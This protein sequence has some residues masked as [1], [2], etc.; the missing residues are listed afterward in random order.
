MPR[1]KKQPI[2]NNNSI[3][4][5]PQEIIEE[6]TKCAQSLEYFLGKYLLVPVIGTDLM[7]PLKLWK[8][9]KRITEALYNIWNKQEKN[10]LVLMA[11][12]Q[13]G[14]TQVI[15]GVCVWLMIFNPNYV[16][17]H[18]NRD[19]P[20]GKQTISEIRDMI[21]NLPVWLKPQF[22]TDTKQEGFKFT[23]GSQ[24]VLQASNKPKDKKSSKGRGRRPLFVWVDQ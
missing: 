12:R 17:L 11:S 14:K 2:I 20:Q 16:I 22:E 5:T 3:T 15:E 7:I 6:Y 23:N 8:P 9:Q 21:D 4:Q 10:G 1:P 24:F 13:C 19:L 18:L